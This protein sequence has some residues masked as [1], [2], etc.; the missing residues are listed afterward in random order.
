VALTKSYTRCCG[1]AGEYDY[2]QVLGLSFKFY[3]AQRSGDLPSTNRI[4]WRADAGLDHKAAD[5]R[6]V[7]GGWYDAGDNV[8]FNLPMAW[9][10]GVLA[11]SLLDFREVGTA[12]VQSLLFDAGFYMWIQSPCDCACPGSLSVVLAL[13]PL[14]LYTRVTDASV[15]ANAS[16]HLL[17]RTTPLLAVCHY[18]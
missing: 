12:A 14:Q 2:A 6:D 9:S 13:A 7:T 18:P 1:L 8:K 11:W 17:H 5:G 3:E 10:A 4:S 16:K 15:Y